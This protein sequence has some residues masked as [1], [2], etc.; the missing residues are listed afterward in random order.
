VPICRVFLVSEALVVLR[1]YYKLRK[2]ESPR[3]R[4]EA[5]NH[6]P[7]CSWKASLGGSEVCGLD[8]PMPHGL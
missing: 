4:F 6:R 5:L 8:V 3:G 7:H 2:T 1:W